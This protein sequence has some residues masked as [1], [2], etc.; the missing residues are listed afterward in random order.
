M[1]NIRIMLLTNPTITV[2]DDL[3]EQL[4]KRVIELRKAAGLRQVDVAD[5]VGIIVGQ[6]G[7]YERGFRRFPVSIIPKLAE[8][9][10]CSEADLL[11][12]PSASPRKRG[13]ASRLEQLAGRLGS[14]PRSK[15]AMILD[16]MEGAIDKAS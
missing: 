15:Q 13:P 12:A 3:A 7:H 11:G 1:E 6:Y 10:G 14:L 5:S 4:P 8:A 9:L 16:M 2:S